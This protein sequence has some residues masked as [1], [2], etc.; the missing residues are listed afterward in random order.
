ML[1][2]SETEQEFLDRMYPSNSASID[3]AGDLGTFTL[4]RGDE[5]Y[6]FS[7]EPSPYTADADPM[8]RGVELFRD[9]RFADAI[10][11]MEAAVARDAAN[12]EAWH[13]LGKC[14]QEC[15]N[16]SQ[17]IAAL[18]RAV[19]SNPAVL[20][21]YVDLAVSHTNNMQKDNAMLALEGWLR[22]N[23]RYA[24]FA[25]PPLELA[26]V[27][28]ETQ[29]RAMYERQDVLIDC[30]V[31]AAQTSPDAVDPA[32]QVCLGLLYRCR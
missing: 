24:Q 12:A 28:V 14:H 2:Q 16:D 26:N 30:Y 13:Y 23:P 29:L 1:H 18:R 17:A 22:N 31:Q 6:V 27:D 21:A 10:L 20:E 4:R 15:D 3:W 11:A 8:Q 32:V 9:G 7:T 25:P 5:Q 19:D